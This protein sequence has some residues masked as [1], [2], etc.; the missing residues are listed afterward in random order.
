MTLLEFKQP[1]IALCTEHIL[2]CDMTR[3]GIIA[4]Q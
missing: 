3:N 1:V 2:P 4:R